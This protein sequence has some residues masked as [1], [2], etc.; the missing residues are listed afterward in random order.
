MLALRV[1]LVIDCILKCLTVLP[2]FMR[3][4]G[5]VFHNV[6]GRPEPPMV[7]RR[8]RHEAEL[9]FHPPD[10]NGSAIQWYII[11]MRAKSEPM[12]IVVG[13]HHSF[14]GQ[15]FA[16]KL[17]Y[18]ATGLHKKSEYEFRVTAVNAAG[19]GQ[20][21]EPSMPSKYGELT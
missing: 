7:E 2:T 11:E 1:L 20:P 6:P 10:D 8:T 21:S 16:K 9:T 19:S 12:W 15:R 17:E 3:T 4:V 13:R 14:S 18:L 5:V